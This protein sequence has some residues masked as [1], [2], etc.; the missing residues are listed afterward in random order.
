MS[1]RNRYLVILVAAMILCFAV[2]AKQGRDK[3]TWEY[4]IIIIGEVNQPRTND[5]KTLNQYGADGWELI[6][7]DGQGTYF[8]K[9]AK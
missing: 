7:N 3:S 4:K 8:L 9:R 1:L 2:G 5:E 6:S